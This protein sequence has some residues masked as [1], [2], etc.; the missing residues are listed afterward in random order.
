M[1]LWISKDPHQDI[2]ILVFTL[3]QWNLI[4][5]EKIHIGAAPIGP[6]ELGRNK[7]YVFALPARYNFGF[8]NGYEEVECILKNNPLEG[9]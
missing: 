8:L 3:D 5:K 9:T 7:I 1:L 6:S 4:Q 2:P